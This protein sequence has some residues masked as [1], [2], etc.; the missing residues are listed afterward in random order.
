MTSI[1]DGK[2]KQSKLPYPGN[3]KAPRQ[4][5]E[6]WFVRD[7]PKVGFSYKSFTFD[8]NTLTWQPTEI[9]YEADEVISVGGRKVMAHKLTGVI[10]EKAQTTWEDNRGLPLKIVQQDLVIE[11]TFK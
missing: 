4:L 8:V 7:H 6:F 3:G 10:G 11:R 9:K 1:T 5:D 2:S